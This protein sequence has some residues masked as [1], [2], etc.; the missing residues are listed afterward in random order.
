MMRSWPYWATWTCSFTTSRHDAID[1]L[2]FGYEEVRKVRPDIIYV[3]CSGFDQRGPYADLQA[4]DDIIQAASGLTQL[5]PM[6]DGN[7]QPRFV[8]TAIADKVSGLHA[9]YGVLTAIIHKLR[10]GAGSVR[11]SADVRIDGQLQHARTTC[12]TTPTC[13]P[14]RVRPQSDRARATVTT[15]ASSIPL[16]NRCAP[17]TVGSPSRRISMTAGSASSKPPATV[18]CSRNLASSIS[19]PGAQTCHRC[20]K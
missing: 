1:R 3:H 19:R 17:R 2:G 16:G 7:P 20:S 13:R 12:V 15:S 6:V 5:L 10:T 4:Y 11:R 8:P 14:P 9:V 18:T